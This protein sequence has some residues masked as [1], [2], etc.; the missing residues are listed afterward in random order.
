[1]ISPKDFTSL[2][3]KDLRK[4]NFIPSSVVDVPQN[5]AHLANKDSCQQTF[6]KK[7]TKD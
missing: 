5:I 7:I 2:S 1:M 4:R 3:N 6:F